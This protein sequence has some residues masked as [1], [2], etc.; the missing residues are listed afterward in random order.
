MN[1]RKSKIINLVFVTTILVATSSL[2][3]SCAKKKKHFG[4]RLNI[5]SNEQ[6]NYTSVNPF[7][8][9]Y[10]FMHY[11]Y[12]N[13]GKFFNSGYDCSRIS[14]RALNTSRIGVRNYASPVSRSATTRGGFG[15]SSVGH[16]Y[17]SGS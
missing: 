9:Y 7:W 13:H 8:G 17:S 3:D 10:W 16:G 1:I 5:R 15:R 4:Q 2:F 12:W 6:D 14:D 11:G